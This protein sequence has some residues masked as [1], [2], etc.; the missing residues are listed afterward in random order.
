MCNLQYKGYSNMIG[1][2][3]YLTFNVSL[4]SSPS[5]HLHNWVY[6][7]RRYIDECKNALEHLT[8]FVPISLW[9][10]L[11]LSR[12]MDIVFTCTF[13]TDVKIIQNTLQY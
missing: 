11:R 13:M 12:T 9:M 3:E 6:Y 5:I 4:I 8:V 2:T 10:G 1:E 7:L